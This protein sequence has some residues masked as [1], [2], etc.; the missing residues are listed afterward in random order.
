MG[1]FLLTG[2]TGLLG[3][4]LLRDLLRADV[5]VAVLV[6]PSRRQTARQRVESLLCHWDDQLG[7]SLPRPVMLEGD[8][9]QP[10]LGLDAN[11]IRWVAEFCDA[12]I[13]NAASLQFHATSSES[14]PWRSNLEGTR[15]VL[16]LCRGTDIRRFHHVSTAY[17]CGLR[18]GVVYESELDVGQEL[19]NDY[20]LSKVQ[21]EK[22]VRAA[23]FLETP[24]VYRP[25]I[26]I[27]DSQTGYT[28]TFHGFYAALQLAYTIVRPV[29]PNE[30]GK[31]GD[32]AVRLALDGHETKNLVPV[33]WV[34]AVMTHILRHPE[35]HGKTY[36]LT[37][38]HP[39]TARL[40][41]DILEQ[42]AGFY[43]AVFQQAGTPLDN[44]TEPE[45]FFYDHIRVYNSYWRDDPMFDRANTLAAAPH[46]PCPRVDRD[47]LMKL[48]RAVIEANFSTPRAKAVEPDFDAQA[49]LQPLLG[50]GT[51]LSSS[52]EPDH[53]WGLN[54]TGHGG[55]Q[56]QLLARDGQL[57]GAEQ[58]LLD[59]R[60]QYRMAIETF[61]ELAEGRLSPHEAL[62]TGR[63]QVEGNG[64][65]KRELA[66][67]LEQV[68]NVTA[69][70]PRD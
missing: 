14:E 66:A 21:A 34:S 25:A 41:R 59:G 17:V 6:R 49:H 2:A 12:V 19:S 24:T 7:V 68:V 40:F 38:T 8:I 9:T 1:Y 33:D 36:H 3:N 54:I 27:G 45:R 46:L 26:I 11:S 44:L 51:Q 30:S 65:P 50:A 58:G 10:D 48:S 15:N 56:W 70:L 69:D 39:I 62:E 31:V 42:A 43:G 52:D 32:R 57:L 18:H 61:A 35:H 64:V 16:D 5:P 55:G 60:S 20:E 4:Y 67:L 47:L 28:T 37:P 29:E 23:D 22:L 63:V 13:H 53:I